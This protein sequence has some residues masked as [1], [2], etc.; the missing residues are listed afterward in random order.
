MFC[1]LSLAAILSK[2]GC[3]EEAAYTVRLDGGFV[4]PEPSL[5]PHEIK[6][7]SA[8]TA[9]PLLI[10]GEILAGKSTSPGGALPLPLA[11]SPAPADRTA[12]LEAA[13]QTP[14][15][16]PLRPFRMRGRGWSIAHE[17]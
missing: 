14:Q 2:A 12:R 11:P 10:T 9:S 13:V 3:R 17:L 6:T 16:S 7:T 5:P 1:D 8:T 4:L 15:P